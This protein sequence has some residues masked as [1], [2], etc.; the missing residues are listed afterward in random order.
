MKAALYI[1]LIAMTTV[2]SVSVQAIPP[3]PPT[4]I[5]IDGPALI[6]CKDANTLTEN[7][8]KDLNNDSEKVV[9]FDQELKEICFTK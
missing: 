1:A 3:A 7:E 9:S 8:I 6:I 2:L 5:E 4:P